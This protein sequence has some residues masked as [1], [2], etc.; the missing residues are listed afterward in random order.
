MTYHG[1]GADP[2]NECKRGNRIVNGLSTKS[3]LSTNTVF[4]GDSTSAILFIP[5]SQNRI[6]RS[7]RGRSTDMSQS[8]ETL[9]KRNKVARYVL[10]CV[11][12]LHP[13]LMGLSHFC[14]AAHLPLA[15]VVQSTL[16]KS[17]QRAQLQHGRRDAHHIV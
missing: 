8:T 16:T 5:I 4:L 17:N 11:G 14:N 15:A 1:R 13:S 6:G 7:V 2:F 12:V 9:V 3:E 10:R